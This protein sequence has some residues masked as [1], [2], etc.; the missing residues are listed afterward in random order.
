M[1][2]FGT[3]L[4]SPLLT[5]ICS[6]QSPGV[7]R[8]GDGACVDGFLTWVVGI[9]S[10]HGD[11]QV[12]RRVIARLQTEQPNNLQAH[13]TSDPLFLA[14]IPAECDLLIVVDACRGAGLPGSIYRFKWPDSRL[15]KFAGVSSHGIGLVAALQ[16][17]ESLGGLPP[18]VVIFS[19]EAEAGEPV[20][21]L[22]PRAEAAIPEVVSL[23]LAEV[24]GAG[25]IE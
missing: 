10:A 19:V 22:S 18:R 8:E 9:G 3:G 13:A 17:A 24:A 7:G 11:D 23:V 2:R 21:T 6:V 16:L 20:E 12:G 4:H 25:R 1:A 14:E 5:R 15:T